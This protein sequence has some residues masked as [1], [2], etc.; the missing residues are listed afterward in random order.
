MK[1][2]EVLLI[3]QSREER[4][5]HL[6]L[7]EA[8]IERGGSSPNFKGLLAEMLGTTIPDT[9][10]VFLCHACHNGK[11]S[12][13]KHLYWG[14]RKDNALDYRESPNWKSAWQKMVE[15]HGEDGARQL[16]QKAGAKAKGWRQR[17]T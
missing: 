5:K 4:R 3:E 9:K 8:C 2:V 16:M 13:W 14:S 17:K 7:D 11:C 6:R 10:E 1:N 12:N 15:K